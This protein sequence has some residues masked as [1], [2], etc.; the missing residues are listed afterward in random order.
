MEVVLESLQ[1]LYTNEL[2]FLP[3]INVTVYTTGGVLRFNNV[4][5][6]RT[7]C[8]GERIIFVVESP[9]RKTIVHNSNGIEIGQASEVTFEVRGC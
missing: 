2:K 5:Q 7:L 3:G 9:G 1:A 6:L 8:I 4:V